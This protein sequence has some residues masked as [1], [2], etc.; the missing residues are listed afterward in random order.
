MKQQ[1]I[2]KRLQVEDKEIYLALANAF[3]HSPAVL[4][5][6]PDE[7][8]ENT[9]NEVIRS[10]LYTDAFLI[11]QNDELAGYAVLSKSFSQE[12]GGQI[13][14]LDELSILPAFQSKGIGQ[15]YFSFVHN[16]YPE[17]KRFRLEVEAD[18]TRAIELYQRMGFSS[19]VYYQMVQ[20][21]KTK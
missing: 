4:K 19:H 13:I 8:I 16:Q 9:F 3:Y 5:P 7:Y 18:N 15:A 11:Y 17:C 2:F 1:I 10:D 20:E 6:I 21:K 14:W 12:C